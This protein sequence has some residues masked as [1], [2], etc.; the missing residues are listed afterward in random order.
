MSTHR[1]TP[2]TSAGIFHDIYARAPA[3]DDIEKTTLVGADIVGLDRLGTIGD[4]GHVAADLR[5]PQRVADIDGPQASIEIGDEDNFATR[6]IG[7]N[8]IGTIADRPCR[9]GAT[10]ER[11]RPAY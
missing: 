5:G 8:Q 4:S 3:V 10:D 9:M 6:L 1:R 7:N 2:R 11:R